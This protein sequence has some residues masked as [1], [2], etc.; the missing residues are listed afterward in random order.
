M[1]KIITIFIYLLLLAPNV[2]A[3][4]TTLVNGQIIVTKTHGDCKNKNNEKGYIITDSTTKIGFLFIKDELIGKIID[5]KID[6]VINKFI[7]NAQIIK[8]IDNKI[9]KIKNNIQKETECTPSEF[10]FVINSQEDIDINID[11]IKKEFEL[12]NVLNYENEYIVLEKYKE[13]VYSIIKN[14]KINQFHKRFFQNM[15]SELGKKEKIKELKEL[16]TE[17]HKRT[18]IDSTF[19]LAA[20]YLSCYVASN[21]NKHIE[22]TYKYNNNNIYILIRYV[23]DLLNIKKNG[24][25]EMVL[26]DFLERNPTYYFSLIDLTNK[27]L[28]IKAT[29]CYFL[30]KFECVYKN[31]KKIID[32]LAIKK[33]IKHNYMDAFAYF[34]N[35]TGNIDKDINK[36]ELLKEPNEFNSELLLKLQMVK[37]S[38]TNKGNKNE[39]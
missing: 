24:T 34:S 2:F 20:G 33:D 10:D 17:F 6:Y 26:N 25:A 29:R 38:P 12:S 35:K 36:I 1:I 13:E 11:D 15:A 28:N 30:L 3:S 5:N 22:E 18:K 39:F 8:I 32:N 27:I 4:N 9:L 37:T 23:N 21:T 16:E 19:I 31:L 14:K 7:A